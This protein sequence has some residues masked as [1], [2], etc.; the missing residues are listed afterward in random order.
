MENREETGK[1]TMINF[2]NLDKFVFPG[3]G[4]YGIPQIDPVKTYPKGEFIP[5]NY[6]N[7][8]QKSRKQ[9]RALLC[10]R[11]P[12]RPVLE[13]TLYIYPDTVKV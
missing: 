7:S 5:M 9:D 10:R 1:N 4:R 12:I 3:I 6:A 2:E 11:L 8:A 13:Q